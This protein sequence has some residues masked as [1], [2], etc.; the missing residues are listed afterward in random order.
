[1]LH[2]F[3]TFLLVFYEPSWKERSSSRCPPF[4]EEMLK[5][6]LEGKG[7]SSQNNSGAAVLEENVLHGEEL[8][9]WQAPNEVVFPLLHKIPPV[10]GP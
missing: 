5:L 1:M 7:M 9:G 3:E 4:D 8:T 2:L 10:L 6:P